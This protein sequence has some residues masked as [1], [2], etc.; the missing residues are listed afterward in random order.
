MLA[1][2]LKAQSPL[3]WQLPAFRHDIPVNTVS[4]HG[5][6]EALRR[7]SSGSDRC[8]GPPVGDLQPTDY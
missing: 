5:L 1:Q 3:R 4:G 7:I 8:S 2:R 6:A